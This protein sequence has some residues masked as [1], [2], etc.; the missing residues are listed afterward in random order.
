MT[1]GADRE[2]LYR[3]LERHRDVEDWTVRKTT[4][5][6]AWRRWGDADERGAST[7]A[8]LAGELHRDQPEGRGSATFELASGGDAEV[9]VTGAMLR[10]LDAIGPIWR[11]P[12][13]AAPARVEL[14]DPAIDPAALAAAVDAVVARV[15]QA[16]GDALVGGLAE[17]AYDEVELAT[18][19]GQRA[20]WRATRV[21]LRAD[22]RAGDAVRTVTRRARRIADLDLDDLI[23]PAD[24]AP[25]AAE[26][27]RAI[28]VVLRARAL[29]HGGAGLL[30]AVIAQADAALERQGLVRYHAGKPIAEGATL[31]LESDGTLP[32]GWH[33]AP[34]GDRGEPVR[35]FP[36]VVNGVA[37]GLGLDAREAAL[38][39]AQPNGGVRGLVVPPGAVPGD[40]LLRDDT[41]VVDD[42][43][44]LE[45]ERTTGW[46]RAEIAAGAM[47]RARVPGEP[48]PG[49]G[50]VMGRPP[51]GR[52]IRGGILRG[53]ALEAVARARTSR[54]VIE[55]PTYR[56]P[57]LWHLG[58]LRLG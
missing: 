40:E 21:E 43:A 10:A 52:P 7:R 11:T 46:F 22:V 12:S 14:A 57:A 33:S 50:E 6:A 51:T 35:R 47:W 1:A 54:E 55:L 36:L 5:R 31:T 58:I 39:G 15:A 41:L 28:E 30:D 29:L 17:V 37:A 38:R 8:R 9:V 26:R 48:L 20:Q 56:G 49:G 19:R 24:A 2:R 16:A 13:P 34:L 44:W 3:A 53:D 18:R 27:P 32:F 25:I 4:T 45:L 23:A 42:L